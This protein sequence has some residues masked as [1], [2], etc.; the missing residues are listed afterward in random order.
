MYGLDLKYADEALKMINELTTETDYD[1]DIIEAVVLSSYPLKP[2]ESM[3]EKFERS[4]NNK[5]AGKLVKFA[6]Y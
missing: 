1:E 5:D 2:K 6:R 3:L 4:K